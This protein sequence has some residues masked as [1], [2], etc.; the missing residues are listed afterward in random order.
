MNQLEKAMQA[1][2]EGHHYVMESSPGTC[3]CDKK[4][5]AADQKIGEATH[6]PNATDQNREKQRYQLLNC[7]AQSNLSFQGSMAKRFN[8]LVV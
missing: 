7:A 8:K 4:N 5:K 2:T 3:T 1:V 6:E